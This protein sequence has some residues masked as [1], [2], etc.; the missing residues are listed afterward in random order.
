[1]SKSAIW[2][3]FLIALSVSAASC[4]GGGGGNT[5]SSTIALN[6]A[7]PSEVSR[8]DCSNAGPMPANLQATWGETEQCTDMSA[9]PPSV[10][11]SPTV[12]CPRNH[13]DDCLATVPFFPCSDDPSQT[14]GA[15]GRFLPECDA[16]ELPDHYSGAAAHEM[17]HYL[18]RSSGRSDWASHSSPEWSCQ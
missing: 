11:F 12:E 16:I 17:I 18:L 3:M 4:G 8:G 9:S 2:R 6:S 1:M 10:I 5:E 7:S 13:Q 14:C 15:V